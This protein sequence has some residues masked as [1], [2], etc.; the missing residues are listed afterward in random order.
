MQNI[1]DEIK[2]EE[3]FTHASSFIGT[4]T[5]TPDFQSMDIAIGGRTYPYCSVPMRI[6]DAFKGAPSKGKFFNAEI[7]GIYEC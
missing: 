3:S 7:R 5:Y 2:R 6:Y 4:V 1:A